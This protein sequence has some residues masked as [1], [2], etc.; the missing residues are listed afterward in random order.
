MSQETFNKITYATAVA[1]TAD[2][3]EKAEEVLRN[4]IDYSQNIYPDDDFASAADEAARLIIK[5]IESDPAAADL[6]LALYQR[7]LKFHPDGAKKKW[8]LLNGPAFVSVKDCPSR[9]TRVAISFHSAIAYI[10]TI[11]E[12]YFDKFLRNTIRSTD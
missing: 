8:R 11:R 1:L 12:D 10:A 4:Y 9:R 5:E 7:S 6:M 3:N 2:K